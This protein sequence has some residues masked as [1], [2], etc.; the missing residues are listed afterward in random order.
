VKIEEFDDLASL[1]LDDALPAE[2]LADF[3]RA[4]AE[5]PELA[6]RFVRLGRVHGGLR[7]LQAIEAA[8]ALRHAVR[9]RRAWLAFV[10]LGFAAALAIG[11][12]AYLSLPEVTHGPAEG[13]EG[14][15]EAVLVVGRADDLRPGDRALLDRLVKLGFRATPIKD[16]VV[17]LE[18]VRGR[19]LVVF[20]ESTVSTEVGD[21][22]AG[23]P[24]PM[25]NCEPNLNPG[26]RLATRSVGPDEV[27]L[28]DKQ[29]EIRIVDAAHPLAG[30]LSGRV[31]VYSGREGFVTWGVPDEATARIVAR[32]ATREA[33]P[34]I[35][36]YE[37]GKGAAG[38]ELPARRVSFFVSSN[39]DEAARLTDEGWALFDAA[40]RWLAPPK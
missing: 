28:R 27:F 32:C 15:P 8:G 16:S 21:R 31:A 40:V 2:R 33:E 12:A 10:P 36:A 5:R 23:A 30:G 3:N 1:Y 19:A 11:L 14:D 4:L 24:L 6:A 22:L 25:L 39:T 17:D 13:R 9:S 18:T 29:R 34:A 37:A 38:A 20:S 7:E 26:L 35:F